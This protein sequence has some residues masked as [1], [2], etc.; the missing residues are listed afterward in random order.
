MTHG[1][2]GEALMQIMILMKTKR[3]SSIILNDVKKHLH[4]SGLDAPH[5]EKPK[6]RSRTWL[7]CKKLYQ[8]SL[9]LNDWIP[10]VRRNTCMPRDYRAIGFDLSPDPSRVVPQHEMSNQRMLNLGPKKISEEH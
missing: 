4:T 8:A 3:P 5:P 6:R 2:L 1:C 7:P 9:E 10:Q